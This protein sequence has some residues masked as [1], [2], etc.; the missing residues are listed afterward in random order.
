MN[1]SEWRRLR[2]EEPEAFAE[3]VRVEKALQTTLNKIK[4]N[5]MRGKAYLHDSLVPL[6]KVNFSVGLFFI[7][8]FS[9]AG[10]MIAIACIGVS[11]SDWI[12]RIDRKP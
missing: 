1:T 11:I 5:K 4:V 6:D 9:G 12:D 8:L 3:A 10:L 7:C 2:D